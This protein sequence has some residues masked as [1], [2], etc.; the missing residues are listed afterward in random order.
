MSS[1]IKTKS[2]KI[3]PQNAHIAARHLGIIAQRSLYWYRILPPYVK[4]SYDVEDMISDVVLH[5]ISRAHH[6]NSDR[7]KES[8][9]VWHTA[10]NKCKSIIMHW[11]TKQYSA[12]GTVEL[13]PDIIRKLVGWEAD[14]DRK[15]DYDRINPILDESSEHDLF[16]NSLNVVERVIE[17]ASDQLL[18]LIES[19]FTGTVDPQIIRASKTHTN[20]IFEELK[21]V[22]KSQSATLEDFLRVYRYVRC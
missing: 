11:R 13:T 2:G 18:N 10:D 6:H 19:I 15:I 1:Y 7:G 8:T 5:V 17:R 14:Q 21:T 20:D 9:F 16:C 4:N 12:C 22:A 3:V